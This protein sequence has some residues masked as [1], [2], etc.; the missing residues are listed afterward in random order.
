MSFTF[1]KEVLDPRRAGRVLR[2]AGW[3]HIR[4]QSVAEHSWQLIRIIL[5]V[6]PEASQEL[7]N[8]CMFHDIAEVVAGDIPFPTKK[9]YPDLGKEHK[10]VE[11]NINEQIANTWNI[12]PTYEDSL[13]SKEKYIYKVAHYIEMWEWAMDEIRMGNREAW[14]VA[15][16]CYK[17][18]EA[19]VKTTEYSS[20]EEIEKRFWVYIER[21]MNAREISNA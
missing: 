4:E 18:F 21:R 7:L 3:P 1:E 14:L 19:T 16:R 2:Y 8:F 17:G 15:D 10:M 13:T 11:E 20:F 9:I 5:M 12:S 6:Y